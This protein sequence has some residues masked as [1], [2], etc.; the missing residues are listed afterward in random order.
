MSFERGIVNDGDP[1]QT[2]RLLQDENT[3]CTCGNPRYA[4]HLDLKTRTY[5]YCLAC[6]NCERFT[7]KEMVD[8]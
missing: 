1:D 8:D 3:I 4:H 2:N 5:T 7:R 6:Q